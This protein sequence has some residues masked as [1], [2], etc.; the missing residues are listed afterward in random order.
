MFSLASLFKGKFNK[1][2]SKAVVKDGK[3]F[4]SSGEKPFYSAVEIPENYNVS[5]FSVRKNSGNI[6]RNNLKALNSCYDDKHLQDDQKDELAMLSMSTR[7]MLVHSALVHK[8]ETH[9]SFVTKTSKEDSFYYMLD[10]SE[11]IKKSG[12]SDYSLENGEICHISAIVY[13]TRLTVAPDNLF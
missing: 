4:I 11:H 9:L 12:V 6:N 3:L 7:N 1:G 5:L 8:D 10:G 13:R 2:N